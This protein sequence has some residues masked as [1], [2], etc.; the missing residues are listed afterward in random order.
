M[1][2]KIVPEPLIDAFVDQNAHLGTGEQKALRLV[3]GGERGFARHGRKAL[4]EVLECF[5]ALQIVE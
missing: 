4:Q 3:E 1:A 2:G 5:A